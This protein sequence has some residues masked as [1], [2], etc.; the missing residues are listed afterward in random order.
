VVYPFATLAFA[1]ALVVYLFLH[2]TAGLKFHETI[3]E[4]ERWTRKYEMEPLSQKET[5]NN[6]PEAPLNHGDGNKSE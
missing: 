2:E 5:T 3:E 6:N 1:A 4:T